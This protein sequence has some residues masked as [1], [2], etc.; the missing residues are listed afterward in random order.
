MADVICVPCADYE[1]AH[2]RAAMEALLAHAGGLDWVRPG[3]RIG[4]FFRTGDRGEHTRGYR[5]RDDCRAGNH[6]QRRGTPS[7][8]FRRPSG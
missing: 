8:C 6:A 1:P 2:C 3:M 5:R 4:I 7:G